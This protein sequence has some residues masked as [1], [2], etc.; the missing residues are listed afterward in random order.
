M[1]GTKSRGG[2]GAPPPPK[3]DNNFYRKVSKYEL[4]KGT[5]DFKA[6]Y[7]ERDRQTADRIREA[8]AVQFV[9][10]ETAEGMLAQDTPI[11]PES[12]RPHQSGGYGAGE[13]GTTAVPRV[14]A[15]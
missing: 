6:L 4:D 11:A 8:H 3:L 2:Y 15:R 12:H 9:V 5:V 7:R 14:G 13:A 1:S 10:S